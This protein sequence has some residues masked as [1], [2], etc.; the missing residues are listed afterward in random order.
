MNTQPYLTCPNGGDD[1]ATVL[2]NIEDLNDATRVA[3]DRDACI[4]YSKVKGQEVRWLQGGPLS[5]K[6]KK[7]DSVPK[8]WQPT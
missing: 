2:K 3:K 1:K 7:D 8:P 6:D 5:V 4:W